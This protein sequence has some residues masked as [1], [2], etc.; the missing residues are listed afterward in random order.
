MQRIEALARA[1]VLRRQRAQAVNNRPL[2][3]ALRL[4]II[5]AAATALGT[6]LLMLPISGTRRALHWNEALFTATSGL[7]TTG[8]SIITPGQ[9][10]SVFGQVVL[11]LLMETGGVGFMIGAVVLFRAFGRAISLE[12]RL[13]LRDSMGLIA[14]STVVQLGRT[15][16]TIALA[17][18][19][20]GALVL[21]LLWLPRYGAGTAAYYAI[22]HT[23]S[24]FTN[25][26]FD[27][28]SRAPDAPAGFPA[29]PA[30]LLVLCALVILGSIGIPVIY[31]LLRWPRQ[32]RLT[33]H[34][35][36]T[37]ITVAILLLIGTAGVFVGESKPGVLF[38]EDPWPR[39]LLLAFFHSAT[40][41]TAGFVLEPL[42]G[43]D[44]SSVLV[45]TGL[46]FI[47][48][49]P[50]S[51]GGGI[52]TSTV[53][54]LV[55]AMWSYVRGRQQIVA[56]QRSIGIETVQKAAAILLIGLAG[57]GLISWLML[58][59]QRA[60]MQEVVFEVVSAAATCGFTLGLTPR[61]DLIG[62]LLIAAT[63]FGGRLGAL[64]VVAALTS[65]VIE[66]PI[67]YPEERV[68]IG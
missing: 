18:Q 11:L 40:S 55:L 37:L 1:G 8:L 52:S 47:G 44:A 14:T 51:M 30:S 50:G 35:R 65:R 41:R 48:G 12:E 21:W 57:V 46:M 17:I 19:G 24:A 3:A 2:R 54:V 22:W 4:T 68:L 29:D 15:I 64:T 62:Q 16:L 20:V 28:F 5:L 26:S 38:A 23:V 25:A 31:D 53:T 63:M 43:M 66:S 56:F 42:Q 67:T 9:D 27:L 45:L 36:L 13:S 7:A 33:L 61:L 60:T 58:L 10:L 34:T 32:R 49:S 59:T 39:R 6:L